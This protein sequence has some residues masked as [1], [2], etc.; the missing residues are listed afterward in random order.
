MKGGAL[1]TDSR[2][3]VDQW[4]LAQDTA[5][6]FSRVLDEN[7]LAKRSNM[8]A[9]DVVSRVL[10]QRF[11][12]PGPHVIAA[13]KELVRHPRAFT[14]AC[15]FE[16]SRSD[17]LL[18]AFAEGPLWQWFNEGR[19]GVGVAET[20]TWLAK[21]AGD[22]EAPDWSEQVRTRVA[23]GLLAAVRDFGM[24]RGAVLKEFAPPSMSPSGF[25]YVAFRL[26]EHGVVARG[27]ITSSVWKRWRLQPDE[28][29]HLFAEAAHLGVLR[30]SQ[31]GTVVRVDWEL[32]SLVEVARAVA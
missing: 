19:I 14:E 31:A 4:D 30:K 6:N 10:S 32:P 13:L 23:R 17:G 25:A 16:A 11:V 28:V 7:L 15:Y 22:G 5:T 26:H 27:L 20:E 18:A 2:I 12:E 29:E 8:R 24:L 9:H 1:L 21:L 3:L